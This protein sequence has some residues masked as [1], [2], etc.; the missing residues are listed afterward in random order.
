MEDLLPNTRDDF[1]MDLP[2]ERVESQQK[3]LAKLINSMPIMDDL[4]SWFD[5]AIATTRDITAIDLN[6]SPEELKVQMLALGMLHEMLVAKKAELE[7]YL[8][9]IEQERQADGR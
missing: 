5:K 9:S 8:A 2:A 7:S 1:S 4:F 3:E 6:Q